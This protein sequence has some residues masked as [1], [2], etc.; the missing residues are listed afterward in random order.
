MLSAKSSSRCSACSSS[1]PHLR[2]LCHLLWRTTLRTLQLLST[3][4]NWKSLFLW[5][6]QG[7][8]PLPLGS[9]QWLLRGVEIWMTRSWT[10]NHPRILGASFIAWN[11]VATVTL[12]LLALCPE[13]T[14]RMSWRNQDHKRFN[15]D[16]AAAAV[17]ELKEKVEMGQKRQDSKNTFQT[18]SKQGSQNGL[19][20][21][22]TVKHNSFAEK[23]KLWSCEAPDNAW[24]ALAQMDTAA[25]FTGQAVTEA[26][27]S[28]AT[29]VKTDEMPAPYGPCRARMA[30]LWNGT[31]RVPK[32]PET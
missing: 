27:M 14:A 9:T 12:A 23:N 16:S 4:L 26:V 10:W 24:C 3:S 21:P 22:N 32:W 2:S 1:G 29:N 8:W 7:W 30:A 15:P 25:D 6:A 17:N 28:V 19:A 31:A 20:L 5:G 13:I 11:T 18:C